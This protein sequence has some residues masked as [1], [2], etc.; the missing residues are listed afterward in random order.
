MTTFTY[1]ASS[2]KN[3]KVTT[4]DIE[5][6]NRDEAVK[7]LSRQGLTPIS[8]KQAGG[9]FSISKLLGGSKVKNDEL[10]IF[11]RQLSTMIN[12]GVPLIRALNSLEEHA[13]SPAFKNIIGSLKTEIEGGAALADA[14]EKYSE[15]F[16]D[17][18]V[19][20]VRAGEAAGI[21]DDVLNRLALQQE[22]AATIRK[23]IKSA[24]TYPVV[25]IAISTIA[26]FGLMIFVIPRIG[27][28][29]S[30]LGGPDAKLPALTQFMLGLS[31]FMTSFWYI[32]FPALFGGVFM[33]RRY[34]KTPAGK[35]QFHRL[36]LKVP[37]IS[38]II[39]KVAVARFARTYASLIGAGV[40]VI[41]ALSITAKAVGNVRYE[42]VI[43]E[44]SNAVQNGEQLSKMIE[45]HEDLFPSILAQ[46][47]AVGEETGQ[48][49]TVLVKV[50]NF[51][52]EEVDVAIEGISSIIEPVMIVFMGGMVGVIAVSVMQPIATLSQNI[53]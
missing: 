22:K 5:A 7:V 42:E 4:G 13:S 25:L 24:M 45:K 15:T 21:L 49:D 33:L 19:N 31:G 39:K 51:Y 16:S 3:G 53:K 10:V 52:E 47:L 30:D 12:A 44:A 20:M 35:K 23:K 32:I 38:P 40:S 6:P 50:A 9:G 8:V 41:D 34:I 28:I 14:L 17:I 2:N 48:T 18:Y 37:A 43:L 11:T 29:L 36:I 46:M 26:F 27:K 1:T